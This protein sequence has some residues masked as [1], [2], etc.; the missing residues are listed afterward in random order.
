VLLLHS[1]ALATRPGEPRRTGS[2]FTVSLVLHAVAAVLVVIVPLLTSDTV[3][4][5]DT[6]GFFAEPL[7]LAAPPPPPPAPGPRPAHRASFATA[8]GFVAPVDVSPVIEPDALELGPTGDGG[9]VEGGAPEGLVGGIVGGLHP[10]APPPPPRVVRVS[11]FAAP[12]LVRK[13]APS[14]PELAL[15][16]R[17]SGV[18]VVEA[19]VD[20]AGSVT[21]A[22]VVSGHALLDSA[23]LEAVRQWRYQPLLLG[24]E[25]TAFVV[26]VSVTFTLNQ[27]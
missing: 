16:A 9:G 12:K 26:T 19:E 17:V 24:G 7:A 4:P 18:V 23:A 2:S 6:T 27:G 1:L 5:R 11:S 20:A 22:R 25:P 10:A 21:T 14:Y 13:V 15:R 8:P 3:E